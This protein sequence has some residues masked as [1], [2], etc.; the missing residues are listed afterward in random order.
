MVIGFELDITRYF[1]DSISAR[2]DVRD[3]YEDAIR[4]LNQIRDGKLDLGLGDD[5][6]VVEVVTTSAKISS[7]ND[8]FSDSRLEGFLD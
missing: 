4:I 7:A 3:R 1:L 2:R 8:I 6:E 5:G